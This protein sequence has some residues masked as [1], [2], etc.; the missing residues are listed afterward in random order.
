MAAFVDCP[1]LKSVIIPSS[2]S[3]IAYRAFGYVF[4]NESRL[5]KM[6]D[7]TIY[8]YEG[9]IAETYANENGF[10]FIPLDDSQ[11]ITGDA[12]GDGEVTSVDVTYIQRACAFLNTGIDEET[13][14]FADVDKNGLLEIIDA[15]YIQRWLAHIDI[16]Y[17]IG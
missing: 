5:V 2:V 15:T 9:T 1:N 12:D 6:E 16:P 7:F 4:D 11:N 13:L 3:L 14:M 8:G 17:T 10:T